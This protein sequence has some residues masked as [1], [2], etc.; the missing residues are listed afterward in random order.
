MKTN[1]RALGRTYQT[2]I[3][4]RRFR[5]HA[6]AATVLLLAA[7]M[8]I[9]AVRADE[10]SAS[11]N[12]DSDEIS[13]AYDPLGDGLFGGAPGGGSDL[14]GVHADSFGVRGS[15]D[16]SGQ[17]HVT[18]GS[19]RQ[20][21]DDTRFGTGSLEDIL[22][23]RPAGENLAATAPMFDGAES[24]DQLN[25]IAPAS[26]AKAGSGASRYAGPSRMTSRVSEFDGNAGDLFKHYMRPAPAV[27][28]PKAVPA[29]PAA[30]A[31]PLAQKQDLLSH[32]KSER[33]L[34]GKSAATRDMPLKP[35][36]MTSRVTR[37]ERLELSPKMLRNVY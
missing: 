10:P 26:D 33:Q 34:A 37:V 24:L 27:A 29:A 17:I 30:P 32:A 4:E 36:E 28:N 3:D 13:W 7:G 6:I 14:D 5:L 25:D 15:G 35:A 18:A 20:L 9:S 19:E 8:A 1:L 16:T 31:A 11:P 12:A 23:K 2:D 21:A 22:G